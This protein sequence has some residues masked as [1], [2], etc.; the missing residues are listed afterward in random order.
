MRGVEK[1]S[2][3]FTDDQNILWAENYDLVN[4]V[5]PI[6]VSQF[7][8]Y[9]I[10][11]RYDPEETKFIIDGLLNGFSIGYEGPQDRRS[12]SPNHRLKVGSKLD[13][14]NKVMAEVKEKRYIGPL[15][16][17]QIPWANF[18]QSPLSLVNKKGNKD[19]FRLVF[20]LSYPAGDSVNYHTPEHLKR[21]S[22]F[23][24][25]HAIKN[26]IQAGPGCYYTTADFSAAFRQLPLKRSHWR[27]LVMK[28]QCPIDGRTYYF[29]DK[30]LCFGSGVSCSIF[31][32]VSNAVAFISQKINN[33]LR[34][35][36]FLDD[37]LQVE[38]TKKLSWRSL[39]NYRSLCKKIS[40]P[41]SEEKTTLPTQIVVFLGML[42][43][44]VTQTVS[45]PVE[46]R[47]KALTQIDNLLRTKVTTVKY[48]QQ[49]TGL[50]NF[51]CRA[52]VPGRAF[53]RRLYAKFHSGMKSHYHVRVDKEM[54]CDLHVW[55]TFLSDQKV[56]C[57]PFVDFSSNYGETAIN[58]QFFT[59]ASA[60]VD[61][62]F[63]G[64]FRGSWFAYP[65]SDMG[66]AFLEAMK[67]NEISI[68]YLELFALF[69]GVVRFGAAF[70][71]KRVNVFCDNQSVVSMINNSTSSCRRSMVLI[72][73]LTL[74]SL[75]FNC[76]IFAKWVKSKQ[77]YLADSLSRGEFRRFW[78]LAPSGTDRDMTTLPKEIWPIPH[79]WLWDK[80]PIVNYH[81]I[82]RFYQK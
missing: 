40:F 5:T 56:L 80:S 68:N 23:D 21:T 48:L 22:Y 45:I 12:L 27:W 61:K 44:S 77:N 81:D 50:L 76:R 57:R 39:R 82:D 74:I 42:L 65:W 25:D 47:N 63:A 14:W 49:L 1:F 16:E 2:L 11:Y 38:R 75:K 59:D 36:N 64:F 54:R 70:K 60:A 3:R 26:S 72:R 34:P 15:K 67:D 8:E 10:K 28:A 37:F 55:Q 69:A 43:N 24:V 7:A 41:L 18:I 9:L 79:S 53:T 35:T 51:I 30:N 46:K 4:L 17:S 33:T 31:Q 13:L 78:R 19:K 58:Q 29:V 71:N 52:V 73:L 32:R 62:G 20:D 6:D 66:T